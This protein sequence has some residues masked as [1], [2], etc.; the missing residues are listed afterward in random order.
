MG[1]NS[2]ACSFALFSVV[3]MALP[4]PT[5]NRGGRGG[6]F[7]SPGAAAIPQIVIGYG[8][9]GSCI[10]GENRVPPAIKNSWLAVSTAD[11]IIVSTF[12]V[13]SKVESSE[14]GKATHVR[15]SRSSSRSQSRSRRSHLDG[16]GKRR[17]HGD[18]SIGLVESNGMGCENRSDHPLH[19][20]GLV[21]RRDDRPLD[22]V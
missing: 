7:Q 20:V 4:V 18:R 2:R 1:L 11:R 12:G 17:R 15:N 16:S 6:A 21:D 22:G 8:Q 9:P 3:C 10:C 13:Q 19:H 5:L 14:E